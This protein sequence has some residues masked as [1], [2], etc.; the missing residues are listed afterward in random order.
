MEILSIIIWIRSSQCL[1]TCHPREKPLSVVLFFPLTCLNAANACSSVH[2]ILTCGSCPGKASAAPA[3]SAW[4]SSCSWRRCATNAIASGLVV[5]KSGKRSIQNSISLFP[6]SWNLV[7]HF[8]KPMVPL[9][10]FM[11]C[12]KGCKNTFWAP[13]IQMRSQESFEIAH[14]IVGVSQQIS[15]Q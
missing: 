1:S 6:V 15:V 7:I 9:L 10:Y 14:T 4:R 11:S 8:C 13:L 5:S 3:S 12:M 2:G